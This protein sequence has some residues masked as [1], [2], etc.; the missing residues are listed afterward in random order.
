MILQENFPHTSMWLDL[1]SKMFLLK[2]ILINWLIIDLTRSPYPDLWDTRHNVNYHQMICPPTQEYW[3]HWTDNPWSH[4][5]HR[6]LHN[7][8]ID[9]LG[10]KLVSVSFCTDKGNFFLRLKCC[11]SMAASHS[12]SDADEFQNAMGRCKKPP[13]NCIKHYLIQKY[14]G[15][16]INCQW[17]EHSPV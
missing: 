3:T 7:N 15:T 1:H 2:L 4:Q 12:S 10:G 8:N 5:R 11:I 13:P 16:S 17:T 14:K 6:R 9:S